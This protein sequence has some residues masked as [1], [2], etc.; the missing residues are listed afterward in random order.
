MDLSSIVT[1]LSHSLGMNNWVRYLCHPYSVSAGG[2][3]A[4]LA[5]SSAT[6]GSRPKKMVDGA[7]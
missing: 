5:S 2:I 1:I 3:K 6:E 7:T 4:S